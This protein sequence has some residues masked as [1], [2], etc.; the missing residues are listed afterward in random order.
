MGNNGNNGQF[1]S[2]CLKIL[3]D[4]VIDI[5]LSQKYYQIKFGKS[6]KKKMLDLD[7][8]QKVMENMGLI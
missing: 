2:E 1:T 6:Q 4:W 5:G 3:K 8:D 7:L